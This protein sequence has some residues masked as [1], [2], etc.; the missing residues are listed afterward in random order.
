M[1]PPHWF[2]FLG[3]HGRPR[4]FIRKHGYLDGAHLLSQAQSQEPQGTAATL[5]EGP[6]ENLVHLSQQVGH[7]ELNKHGEGGP[8]MASAPGSSSHPAILSHSLN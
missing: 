2:P 8:K 3:S 7:M 5:N 4:D 1:C 6:T